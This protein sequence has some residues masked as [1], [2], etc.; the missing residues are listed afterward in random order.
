ML[1]VA[2]NLFL[3]DERLPYHVRWVRLPDVDWTIVRDYEQF[4]SV[5]EKRGL[6]EWVSFDHDLCTE[7]YQVMMHEVVAHESGGDTEFDYGIEKTGYDCA[8][9]LVEYC[10]DHDLPLPTW[11]V[12]SMNPVGTDRIRHYLDLAVRDGYVRS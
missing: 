12:H 3:D 11:R 2:Y 9:W 5:I 7:H 6:P 4:V 10:H 8:K 1:D